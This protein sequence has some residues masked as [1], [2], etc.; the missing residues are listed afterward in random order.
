VIKSIAEAFQHLPQM[1]SNSQPAAWPK[2]PP[3]SQK[4]ELNHELGHGSE[5]VPKESSKS[6][7]NGDITVAEHVCEDNPVQ[8]QD[9][10]P[11][12]FRT[13]FKEISCP[14][15][16]NCI[17][18]ALENAHKDK[19][20]PPPLDYLPG[21]PRVKLSN[22]PALFDFLIREFCHQ[23]VDSIAS[24]LWWMSKQDKKNISPLHRQIVKGRQI[25]LAEESK[26]HLVWIDDRIYIK[27]L[28]EFLLSYAFWETY[29]STGMDGM[30]QRQDRVRKAALGYLRTWLYLVSYEADFRIATELNLIPKRVSWAQFCDF[31][32]AFD[33]IAQGD[34]HERYAYGE[35]RLTRLNL[36]APITIGKQ[37]FQRVTYQYGAYFAQF[38]GPL[39]FGF[40]ILSVILSGLQ[41]ALAGEQGAPTGNLTALYRI[42]LWFAVITI[43][44]LTVTTFMLAFLWTYKVVKEWNYALRNRYSLL[45]SGAAVG[46]KV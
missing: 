5:D 33:R 20:T 29:L 6:F 10:L 39:L 2:Q 13:K 40:G 32:S 21:H 23:D 7:K 31:T 11:S 43:L 27:P 18:T 22:T 38:Y 1:D 4:H 45:K 9:H 8:Q 16:Q 42:S 14:C 12:H 26:L 37:N 19:P 17:L 35:I 44:L 41:V 30:Q 24:R 25:I 36:Y 34:V 3:F 46:S 15:I 28:P